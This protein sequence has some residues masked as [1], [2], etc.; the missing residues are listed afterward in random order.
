MLL[1]LP[2]AC[3]YF[4]PRQRVAGLFLALPRPLGD[5]WRGECRLPGAEAFEPAEHDQ[6]DCCNMGYAAV[7][8]P[9]FIPSGADAVRFSVASDNGAEVRL[10]WSAE[11]DHRPFANGVLVYRDGVLLPSLEGTLA[12]Q[13]LAYLE[14]YR[15]RRS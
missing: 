1:Y 6:N 10:L 7:R 3:P 13:A 5:L 12:A 2:V 15:L 9:R 14:S 4:F 11:R 8:C